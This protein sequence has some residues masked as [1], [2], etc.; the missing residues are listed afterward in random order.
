MNRSVG[1]K[2]FQLFVDFTQLISRE[3]LGIR[4]LL[5]FDVVYKCAG[6]GQSCFD[7]FKLNA[8]LD[9]PHCCADEWSKRIGRRPIRFCTVQVRLITDERSG[10]KFIQTS[11]KL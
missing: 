6:S 2:D 5:C 4:S 3:W 8:S 7:P 1:L 9:I 11:L 10:K